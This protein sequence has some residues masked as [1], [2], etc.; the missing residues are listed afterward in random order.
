MITEFWVGTM[1]I[2]HPLASSISWES[3]VAFYA[4]VVFF[5]SHKAALTVSNLQPKTY[6]NAVQH[7][8]VNLLKN[9]DW[10]G[11]FVNFVLTLSEHPRL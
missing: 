5:P 9:L 11:I 7:K 1:R 10:G 2:N 3:S 6:M 4:A 8:F